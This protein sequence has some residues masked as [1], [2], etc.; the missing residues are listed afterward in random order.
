LQLNAIT[1]LYEIAH[2]S[3]AKKQLASESP[4]SFPKCAHIVGWKDGPLTVNMLPTLSGHAL[5]DYGYD[6]A[7]RRSEQMV[8]AHWHWLQQIPDFQ[9]FELIRIAPMLGIRESYRVK[10]KY[11]LREQDLIATLQNQKH[12]DLIAIADHPCDIHGADGGLRHLTGAY[13]IPYRCMIPAG[14]WQNVL[15]ACR[16]AGF[17]RIAASS[18]RLQ[19][20][21]IQLGHAAG[22][23]AAWASKNEGCVEEIDIPALVKL[24]NAPARYNEYRPPVEF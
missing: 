6:E 11:V 12:D 2:R 1:R 22:V 3:H 23:A 8:Y 4:V 10:T 16:G 18:C 5:I 15:V 24:L 20:T 21:M 17:S 13:G 19:R 14:S 7:L 9:D